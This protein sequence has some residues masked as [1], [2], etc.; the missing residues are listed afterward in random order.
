MTPDELPLLDLFNRLRDHGLPLGVEEYTSVLCAIRAGFGVESR[1]AMAQLCCTVWTKSQEDTR[2]F[3]RLF[4]QMLAQPV[5][6][7]QESLSSEPSQPL[8]ETMSDTSLPEKTTPEIPSLTPASTSPPPLPTLTMEMDEPVQVVQAVRRGGYDDWQMG[9]P[10]FSLLTDYFPVTRRQMK[11]SWR[12]LRRP[13][14][15]GPLEELDVRATVEK[16]GR[17][18]MLL[19]PVL[20]PRRSNRAELVLLIDQDGSMAPFHSLS[21]Q[22]SE[23]IQRGGRLRQVEV[24]YFHDYPD[25]YLYRDAARLEA[26]HISEVLTAISEQAAVLILSDAGAARGNFDPER[27]ERTRVFIEQLRQSIRYYAWLN[28]MP[29]QRWPDTTAGEVARL[30]P[31]F[32]LSRSGLDAAITA[33]RGQYVYWEKM[34]LWMI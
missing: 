16:A 5:T 15:E 7:R 18:G 32:E 34:Y 23:T 13:V 12:H 33:L 21:R 8:P 3:H 11:Q 29:N 30:V 1:H 28:P 17:Q 2:L 31:M 4:D 22:L 9:R 6:P 27:V 25:M 14:R 19:E 20:V 24:Y 10:H 26:R